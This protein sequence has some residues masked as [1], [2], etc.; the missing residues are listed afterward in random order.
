[1]LFQDGVRLASGG[2]DSR[3]WI[4]D[5]RDLTK[6]AVYCGH[7]NDVTCVVS[8]D[9]GSTLVTASDDMTIGFWN[10]ADVDR[11]PYRGNGAVVRRIGFSP[12]GGLIASAHSDG[13]V[14]IRDAATGR[15]ARTI[16]DQ[17]G[18]VS[19]VCFDPVRNR[20]A[21]VGSDCSLRTYDV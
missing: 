15:V 5:A 10:L 4:S 14:R 21:T 2:D 9:D 17:D 16:T 13:L 8:T 19:G 12:D 20:L 6:V 11:P 18:N 3:L 7:L 1:C